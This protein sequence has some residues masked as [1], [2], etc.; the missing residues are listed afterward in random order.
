MATINIPNDDRLVQVL[1]KEQVTFKFLQDA[2]FQTSHPDSFDPPLAV[3]WIK[4]KTTAVHRPDPGAINTDVLYCFSLDSSSSPV[5]KSPLVHPD[6]LSGHVIHIGSGG[7]VVTKQEILSFEKSFESVL[8]SKRFAELW[9][10]VKTL[11][12]L[13]LKTKPPIPSKFRIILQI[14][15]MTGESAFLKVKKLK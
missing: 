9:P 1:P 12:N 6:T 3:G 4:A 2:F 11:I 13:L 5:C 8:K 14:L 10:S 15:L 7:S